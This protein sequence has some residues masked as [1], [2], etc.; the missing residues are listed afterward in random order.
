MKESIKNM[1]LFFGGGLTCYCLLSAKVSSSSSQTMKLERGTQEPAL[2]DPRASN[3]YNK[4][5]LNNRQN[6]PVGGG[7]AKVKYLAEKEAN[8]RYQMLLR[9]N[10]EGDSS[11]PWLQFGSNL[12]V[13][14]NA[15]E[16]FGLDELQKKQLVEICNTYRKSLKDWEVSRREII[17]STGDKL[18]YKIPRDLNLA[19]KMKEDFIGDIYS[20]LGSDGLQ[21]L[22]SSINNFFDDLTRQ[23]VVTFSI[24]DK[25]EIWEY[26]YNVE[27][28]G[29]NGDV[30]GSHG[31]N[32]FVRKDSTS[33]RP[34]TVP[35]RYDHFF[36]L[37]Q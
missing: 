17:S 18:V 24:L 9:K 4:D 2:L 28:I 11:L 21:L 35:S 22:R 8:K 20:V 5:G 33:G 23:R 14:N 36:S 6:L 16:F 3:I 32:D 10:A 1:L 34:P 13:S 37:K 29:E 19:A 31:S 15:E 12:E 25:N 30:I 27:T 7:E 26:K